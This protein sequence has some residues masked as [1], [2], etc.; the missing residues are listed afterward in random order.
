[1]QVAHAAG[2]SAAAWSARCS[3]HCTAAMPACMLAG[4]LRRT[5]CIWWSA[6][7]ALDHGYVRMRICRE[8]GDELRRAVGEW[9][10]RHALER[11]LT[12]GFL[13]GTHPTVDTYELKV[14]TSACMR[15]RTYMHEV[16]HGLGNAGRAP[17]VQS[18]VCCAR[19]VCVDAVSCS[20][21]PAVVPLVRW[22]RCGWSTCCG[23][24]RSWR[25]RAWRSAPPPCCRGCGWAARWRR[26][27]T[28]SCATWAYAPSSTP[29]RC[30]RA[31]AR[32]RA[33]MCMCAARQHH[34]RSVT[35]TAAAGLMWPDVAW[36][37]L[38]WLPP[39]IL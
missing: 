34:L 38:M 26:T 8:R 23:G 12:T 30:A 24:C 7:A 13:D 25:R 18:H 6:Y 31:C 1:M 29:P 2:L 20:C 14:Y 39:S 4:W 16:I 5:A 33:H 36:C 21:G 22:C 35:T 17:W 10:A 3:V 9:Q 37:G 11:V 28:T 32:P 27:A 19:A 15:M